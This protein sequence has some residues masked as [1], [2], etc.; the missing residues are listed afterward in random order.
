MTNN[1]KLDFCLQNVSSD[2]I[3][4]LLN[5]G[6]SID[7]IC[8]AVKNVSQRTVESFNFFTISNLTDEEKIPPEFIVESLVPVGLT[9]ISGAP[10]LRKSFFKITAA[11]SVKRGAAFKVV[12]HG[13]LFVE[14]AVLE[15][16]AE[17]RLYFA[18]VFVGIHAVNHNT[19]GVFFQKRTNH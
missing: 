8:E 10:K 4:K 11:Y 5:D 15:N 3:T 13:K 12:A 18:A 9:F 17:L 14:H 7:D 1:E 2:E 19:A 6:F 16:N